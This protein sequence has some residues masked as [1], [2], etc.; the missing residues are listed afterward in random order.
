MK[1]MMFAQAL[2][3]DLTGEGIARNVW[4]LVCWLRILG[5]AALVVLI[6]TRLALFYKNVAAFESYPELAQAAIIEISNL[7]P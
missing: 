7:L 6:I 3:A 1:P 4:R 5:A 2:A